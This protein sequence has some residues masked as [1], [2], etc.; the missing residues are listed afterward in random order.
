M[1]DHPVGTATI[2][3]AEGMRLVCHEE[4]LVDDDHIAVRGEG[5][6]EVVDARRDENV[7]GVRWSRA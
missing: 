4:G 7:R 6:L 2:C 1:S 5:E 3:F